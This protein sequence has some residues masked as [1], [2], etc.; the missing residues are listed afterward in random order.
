MPG[1]DVYTKPGRWRLFLR[2]LRAET[3]KM[4]CSK[5]EP[6]GFH[7]DA[8]SYAMNFDEGP[9]QHQQNTFYRS[10]PAFIESLPPQ[11]S[12]SSVLSV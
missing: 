11:P 3:R 9:W 8:L 4:N 2:K 6:A 10:P 12:A 5:P 1:D 7:Y